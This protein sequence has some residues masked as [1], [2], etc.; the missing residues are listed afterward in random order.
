VWG[1]KVSNAAFSADFSPNGRWIVFGEALGSSDSDVILLDR[2]TGAAQQSFTGAGDYADAEF[3]SNSVI[4]ANSVRWTNG[5]EEI[6][7]LT[8]GIKGGKPTI[9]NSNAERWPGYTGEF[10]ITSGSIT[11]TRSEDKNSVYAESGGKKRLLRK[12]DSAHR[13]GAVLRGNLAILTDV[14]SVF[15]FRLSDDKQIAGFDCAELGDGEVTWKYVLDD[16]TS[17]S[18]A[19]GLAELSKQV[20]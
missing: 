8:W 10:P 7:E 1:R 19:D 11:L 17:C 2:M 16:G 20:K 5:E 9:R 13:F 12:S 18:L 15:V 4:R 14:R 3:K 6:I